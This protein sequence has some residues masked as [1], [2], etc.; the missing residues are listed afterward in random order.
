MAT[1]SDKQSSRQR[2]AGEARAAALTIERQ[3][4][5][6]AAQALRATGMSITA[7]AKQLGVGYSCAWECINKPEGR[8]A[9]K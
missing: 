6:A 8:F 3:K 4:R 5:V 2:A 1:L 7:I 9:K